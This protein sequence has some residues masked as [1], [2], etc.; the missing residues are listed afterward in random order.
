MTPAPSLQ[1]LIETVR[2][3]AAS[4][5]ALDQL[6]TA[7]QTAAEV[8]EVT[9]AMLS[10]FVDQCRR[11]GRSWTEISKAL[12]VTKQAAHKRFSPVTF[13]RFTPRAKTVLKVANEDAKTL[14][15]NYVGTEHLLLGLFADPEA[16]AAKALKNGGATRAAVEEKILEITPRTDTNVST[17]PFTPRAATVLGRALSEALNFGHNYIGTEHILLALFTDADSMAAKIL[18]DLHLE[19]D[20][21]KAD[22]VKMLTAIINTKH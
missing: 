22:I 2:T 10:H 4:A 5:D 11:S 17:T 15:H 21:V 1:E 19:Y 3:D 16:L 7:S 8:E 20:K 14:G 12:G 6:A 9:D 18:A 13:E